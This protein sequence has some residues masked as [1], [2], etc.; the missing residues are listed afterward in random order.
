MTFH[1]S[2]LNSN[3]RIDVHSGQPTY[4]PCCDIKQFNEYTDLE[5][6]LSSNELA[7]LKTSTTFPVNCKSCELQ[8]SQ[9]QTSLRLQFE[10]RFKNANGIN[11]IEIMP[12]DTCNLKCF[13]CGPTNSSS[14][15]QEYVSLG[16]LNSYRSTDISD[17]VISLINKLDSLETIGI[18]GGEFFL[19]KSNIAIMEAALENNIEEF[20]VVT[21]CTILLEKHLELLSKFKKLEL[22]ISLD[23]YADNY[24][25]MRYPAKWEN[26]NDNIKRIIAAVGRDK[27]KFQSVVQPL[28]IQHITGLLQITNRYVV[29]HRLKNLVLPSWLSWSILDNNEKQLLSNLEFSKL[30]LNQIDQLNDIIISM[31]SVEFNQ[32]NR[33]IFI[34]KMSSLLRHRQIDVNIIS[35]QFGLLTNLSDQIIGEI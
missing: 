21:N 4:K 13:M 23:G 6:Y 12:N 18:I 8:E 3:I 31:N 11:Q 14:L 20:R 22:Q 27:I 33:Q 19:A 25:F 9:N 7:S 24:E 32:I 2:A 26:I 16:W 10:N 15:A 34:E 35:N 29:P 1:C 17:N 30:P 28:N 5:S